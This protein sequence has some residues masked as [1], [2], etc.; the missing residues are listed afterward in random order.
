MG[1]LSWLFGHR[2]EASAKKAKERLMMVL[3]YERKKLPPNFP[4]LLKQD[5]VQVFSKYNQFDVE[6]I[7]VEIRREPNNSFEELW[8]LIPFKS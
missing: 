6:N 7:E 8:I 3:E 5:L 2:Q 1:I 4:E